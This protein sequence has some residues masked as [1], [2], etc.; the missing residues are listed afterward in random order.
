MSQLRAEVE[1]I[2]QRPDVRAALVQTVPGKA[3]GKPRAATKD[4]LWFGSYLLLVIGLVVL[5]VIVSVIFINWYTA[6]VSL[7]VIS[8]IFG[9]AMQ[10]TLSSF[11]GWVYILVRE[12][13]RV[14]DRIRIGR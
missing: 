10:T 3:A 14:G 5:F 8:L 9:F 13:Y 12:P 2:E 4:K 6:I 11:I 1:E 7:S